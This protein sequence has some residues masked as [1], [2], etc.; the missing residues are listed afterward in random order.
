MSIDKY[1]PYLNTYP[2]ILSNY[3]HWKCK[4]KKSSAFTKKKKKKSIDIPLP[5]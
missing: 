3:K 1:R 5:P 2:I 4:K